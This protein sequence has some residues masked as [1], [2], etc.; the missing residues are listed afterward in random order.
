MNYNSHVAKSGK[1]I[2]VTKL[3][4]WLMII[5]FVL[6]TFLPLFASAETKSMSL[7]EK[8]QLLSNLTKKKDSIAKKLKEARLKEAYESGKLSEIQK[9]LSRAQRRLDTNKKYLTATQSA[10]QKTKD[11]LGEIQKQQSFIETEAQE[12]MRSIYQQQR[13]RL[14]DGLL[15]STSVTDFLDNL[16]YQKRVIEYD[17][18]VLKAL[19]DQSENIQ[20]YN[21]IL[22]NEARKMANITQKLQGIQSEISQKKKAQNKIVQKLKSERSVYESAER[23]IEKESIK[24]IYKITEL[25]GGKMDNPDA[26]GK[27]I[28]PIKAR[29]SSPFGPRRHPVFG[30]RSM[31]SGIDLAGPRGAKIKASEGGLVIYSGWYGGYG[32]VV[33]VD[34]SKGYSTLYAHMDKIK[35]KVGQRVKQGQVIGFEGRT[36]YATGPHVHFEVRTKG[37]PQNPVYYL[38]EK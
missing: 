14:I 23:Q 25:S 33:I 30:V 26:T 18:Q 21:K 4:I 22:S 11:R 32:K 3:I 17:R 13:V 10:W 34:H 28:Y 36:G 1:T 20:Q 31:H 37:R 27:F 5:S 2:S 35:A 16:Y 12:R 19:V 15:N 24:L 38:S 8:E 9:Q 6:V 7:H 29:I